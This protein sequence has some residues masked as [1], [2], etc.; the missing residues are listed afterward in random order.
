[1]SATLAEL[2]KREREAKQRWLDWLDRVDEMARMRADAPGR[3]CLETF[4]A[5]QMRAEE[6]GREVLGLQVQIAAGTMER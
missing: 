5:A 1:M 2:R 3:G 6:A 4:R